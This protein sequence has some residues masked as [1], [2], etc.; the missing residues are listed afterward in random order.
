MHHD[1]RN[2]CTTRPAY[3]HM[4]TALHYGVFKGIN[5]MGL[6]MQ[7]DVYHI[8]KI[9]LITLFQSSLVMMV[10]F[11]CNIQEQECSEVIGFLP[12][13]FKS[14]FVMNWISL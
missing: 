9:N 13:Q 4:L 5:F 2:A 10:Y 6:G 3:A 7:I 1:L 11:L 12:K 14:L 8:R